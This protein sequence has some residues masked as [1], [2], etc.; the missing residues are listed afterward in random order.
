V[1]P[2]AHLDLTLPDDLLAVDVA[3]SPIPSPPG[4]IDRDEGGGTA[5]RIGLRTRLEHA[6]DK[7]SVGVGT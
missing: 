4:R 3:G 1:T 7:H 6:V 2:T 5:E